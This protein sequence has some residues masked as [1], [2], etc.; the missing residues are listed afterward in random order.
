MSTMLNDKSDNKGLRS[1]PWRL[2]YRTSSTI[3]DGRPL[4]MLHDFYI[5]ALQLAVRYDRVAG[6]FRSTSLAAA[7]QGFSSFVAR[8]GKMRLIVGADLE[9][10]D[11]KAILQGDSQRLESRLNEEL[12][13]PDA[14]PEQVKNGVTL[15]A[16]MVAHGY[17]EVRVAFRLHKVTGEPIPFD[18]MEDGYVHEKWFIMID[19][20]GN[21]IYASGT[22]NESKTALMLNAENLD[23]H[24]DWTGETER[25]RVE[26]AIQDFENLWNGRISHLPVLTLPEAVRRRLIQFAEG[27]V[28]PVEVDGSSVAPMPSIVPP[29]AI[30]RLKFAVLRDGPRMPGGRYVGM[31]TAPVDPWP[32]QKVVVRRLVETWPYSY[33]LCDEVGLG[34]TIEAGLAFRSLYLSGLAKRILIA[35]PAGLT[36][37]WQR[38]MASKMLMSFSR[39]CTSPGISHAYVFPHTEQHPANSMYETDLTIISTGLLS[40]QERISDLKRAKTFDIVLVDEAHAARRSNPTKGTGALPEYGL[41]YKTLQKELR[42]KAKSL[43]LATATPMQIHPVEVYDLLALTDRVGIFQFDP[44]LTQEFYNVIDELV[45]GR[46]PSTEEWT[47]M[48]R[49]VMV[50]REEDPMFWSFIE[51]YVINGRIRNTVN[52]WLRFGHTPRGVDRVRMLRLIFSAAPLSRVMMRHTRKLLEVYRANGQLQQNLATRHVLRLEAIT[53]NTLERRIYE[54]LEEYC[55]GL[56]AQFQQ[57]RERQHQMV[58]FLLSFLRLR[59]ASSLYAF[60]ET[61]KR[62]LQKVEATLRHQREESVRRSEEERPDLD[63]LI[64][65]YEEDDD[66][67]AVE[68]LLQGRS[69]ADLEWEQARIQAMLRNMEELNGDSSKMRVLLLKLDQRRIGSTGRFKQTVIFTRFYDT[70]TDIVRRLQHARPDMRIGTYSGQ[71]ATW[72]DPTSNRMMNAD[73]EEVKERFLRGEIDILVCTDAAAEGLN[74]QTA[75]LL[76]NFDLGWN[77][78]KIEQRIG[79]IDRIGQKYEHIYVLNLCYAGSEEEVVYGRLLNRLL[80]A[81]LIVGTQQISL[82][83]V[84]PDEFRQLAEGTLTPEELEQRSME[85]LAQQNERSSSMEIPPEEQYEIYKRLAETSR[86]STVPVDLE[87]IW[88]TL[89]DS[90]TLQSAGCRVNENAGEAFMEVNGIDGIPDGTVLTISRTLYEEGLA[91][92]GRRVHFAS[93]GDPF[94]E[95]LLTYMCR[96]E[97]PPC[98]RRISVAVEGFEDMEVVCYA[99][100]CQGVGGIRE[101][102]LI[103]SWRELQGI[104]LLEEEVI[105]DHEAAILREQ[106]EALVREEFE[107]Y[108]VAKRIER[109]NR[110]TAR[111][112]E[113]LNFCIMRDLLRVKAGSDM[114]EALF[115]PVLREVETL[116]E[117]RERMLI[118]EMPLD[119]LRAFQQH[120]AFD[121]TLPSIG[122]KGPVN[123]PRFAIKAAVDAAKRAAEALKSKRSELHVGRVI[124]RLEREA[125]ERRRMIASNTP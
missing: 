23:V 24:C 5:P 35:A 8:K 1:R 99:V 43:W 87:A 112:Q 26:E 56:T 115:W 31:E 102:R 111:M 118:S 25:E 52:R 62:R 17:L 2:T 84:E 88:K 96:W 121:C 60:Q 98:I 82:L 33:L 97:L 77:P 61:M 74:L 44:T 57:R 12:Q 64:Q 75:D 100:V 66:A 101:I 72:F 65:E 47:F 116:A 21:R 50:I 58:S 67:A 51:Q 124:A 91:E 76:I 109:E 13:Q 89:A 22:L 11:V 38:Q 85:R 10:D 45:H 108:L 36:P 59:F 34:K 39:V 41:L 53:F 107:P 37:Q 90:T 105:S 125:A 19:E 54:Q 20:F 16:W 48:R 92:G 73:R 63:V 68:S 32:H 69:Q 110:K 9:P 95:S 49:A 122:E 78:M 106:L 3:I 103:R 40:R 113:L 28:R 114:N 120:L 79:R 14:W 70:L 42:P 46:E 55:Q 119:I 104:K 71:G 81:N 7:S 30:E 94:F 15:L 27:V 80:Q 86:Q 18:S 6:Y 93:Y 117:E 29:S 123:V 4:D 83:P